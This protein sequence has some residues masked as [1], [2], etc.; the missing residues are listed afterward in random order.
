[1]GFISQYKYFLE[2]SSVLYAHWKKIWIPL[3]KHI[4]N[5]EK[6]PGLFWHLKGTLQVL[7]LLSRG[8]DTLCY[9]GLKLSSEW[10]RSILEALS[11]K[12]LCS[13]SQ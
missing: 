8:V 12:I 3:N 13:F 9:L 5:N 4:K 10:L 2:R 11:V 6:E 7:L 1:M